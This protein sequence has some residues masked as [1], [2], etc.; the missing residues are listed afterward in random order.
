MGV[1][2][3]EGR[4][5]L[6]QCDMCAQIYLLNS[7]IPE[8][9]NQ[10]PTGFLV[11]ETCWD[12]DNPQLQLGKYPINDPQALLNPRTDLNLLQSRAL[13]NFNPIGHPSTRANG[14]AGV[15]QVNDLYYQPNTD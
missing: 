4:W 12:L 3:A 2:F 6:G 9:Y 13:W 1:K 15:V 5:A 10:R 11:C 7:L 14:C 8:I